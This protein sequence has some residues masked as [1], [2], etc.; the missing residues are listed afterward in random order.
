MTSVDS[1]SSSQTTIYLVRHGESVANTQNRFGLDTPL[2]ELG[3]TQ[4]STLA[5]TLADVDFDA[6]YSSNLLRARQTAEI[7][8]SARNLHV[9]I[10]PG[11]K[12]R[13][14]GKLSGLR[15]PDIFAGYGEIF[16]NVKTM[17]VSVRLGFKIVPDIETENELIVRYTAALSDIARYHPGQTILVV[18]HQTAMRFFLMHIGY[19]TYPELSYGS[20]PNGSFIKLITDG[21]QFEVSETHGLIKTDYWY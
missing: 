19:A 11:L 6:V 17:P 8:A 15:E 10:K 13:N 16:A 20:I 14:W 21:T 7:L 2:T 12:E 4:A 18:S 9:L 5:T 1:N 3:A